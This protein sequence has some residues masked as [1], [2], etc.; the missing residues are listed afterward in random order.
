MRCTIVV[1]RSL[2]PPSDPERR[3]EVLGARDVAPVGKW[4]PF[5]YE[6]IRVRGLEVGH[7]VKT[8]RHPDTLAEAIRFRRVEGEIEQAIGRARGSRRDAATPL[9]VDILGKTPLPGVGVDE[10][11]TWE[12][13][14]PSPEQSMLAR[15]RNSR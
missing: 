10:L 15:G 13:I 8:E 11:R 4:Y 1:G 2:P 5:S 3:A 14:Q 6:A 9:Q 12:E 7:G